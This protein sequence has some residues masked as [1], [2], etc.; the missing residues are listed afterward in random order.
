MANQADPGTTIGSAAPDSAAVQAAGGSAPDFAT[1]DQAYDIGELNPAA[2]LPSQMGGY[3]TFHGRKISW[4]AISIVI[5]GFLVGGLA[6]I[7]G[8]IWW[9]FWTGAC[10]AALGML[11]AVGINMFEDW[12]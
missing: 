5:V 6:L 12:Y 9:L 7:F 3:E 8:S 11:I 2:L 10:L 4:L 1:P